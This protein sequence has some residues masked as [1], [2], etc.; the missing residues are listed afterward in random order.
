MKEV[1]GIEKSELK[2]LYKLLIF[3]V[4]IH[5]DSDQPNEKAFECGFSASY[6]GA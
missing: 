3:P 4:K 5:S 6:S 2:R 1:L